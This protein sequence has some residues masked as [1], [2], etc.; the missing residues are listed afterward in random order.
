MASVQ[1][2]HRKDGHAQ[3]CVVEERAPHTEIEVRP[4]RRVV[5]ERIAHTECELGS[6]RRMNQSELPTH[7]PPPPTPTSSVWRSGRRERTR[8]SRFGPSCCLSECC[9]NID[10]RNDRAGPG[11]SSVCDTAKAGSNTELPP[12]ADEG[13]QGEQQVQDQHSSRRSP[14]PKPQTA[15]QAWSTLS[16]KERIAIRQAQRHIELVTGMSRNDT[17][18]MPALEI[19]GIS[20]ALKEEDRSR[21]EAVI[22]QNRE[23][24][25]LKLSTA[26]RCKKGPANVDEEGRCA[27]CN[28]NPEELEDLR[29]REEEDT[30]KFPTDPFQDW[31]KQNPKEL[32]ASIQESE[33]QKIKIGDRH[34]WLPA[35]ARAFLKNLGCVNLAGQSGAITINNVKTVKAGWRKMLIT[36]DSGAAESVIPLSENPNYPKQLHSF[37]IW[38]QT[39]SGEAI[40]N[41]GEQKLPV[42]TPNGRMKGMTFQACD[43]TK[44]LAS[45]KRMVDAGHAVI[46]SPEEY[47]GSFVLNLTSGEEEPL[48]ESEGNYHLE[49]WVPPPEALR[50]GFGGQP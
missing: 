49:V 50:A 5:E 6:P 24:E 14:Q 2:F 27:C 26:C 43:V 22:E 15:T 7:V 34:G 11:T 32:L 36:V 41:E 17:N 21:R 12:V 42:M 28:A 4:P 13:R 29:S 33:S 48:V 30:G 18:Q 31:I 16:T 39:A 40:R 25:C 35:E 8:R 23:T 47:G 44:P 10:Q 37:P 9:D 46:F 38:Y 19:C 45:V 3:P 20:A 1:S